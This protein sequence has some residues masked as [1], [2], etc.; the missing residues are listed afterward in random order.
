[1]I[2][3]LFV[4]PIRTQDLTQKL[5]G[6]FGSTTGIFGSTTVIFGSTT[7]IFG[8]TTGIFGSIQREYLVVQREYLSGFRFIGKTFLAKAGSQKM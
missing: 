1:M 7:V 6:E 8:S 5:L 3:C 2:V 4:G